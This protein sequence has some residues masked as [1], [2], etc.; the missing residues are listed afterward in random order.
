MRSIL[1][2]AAAFLMIGVSPLAFEAAASPGGAQPRDARM[3][4]ASGALKGEFPYRNGQLEGTVKWYYESGALGALMDY[5]KNRLHGYT[6]TFY[7][8]GRLKKVVRLDNNRPVGFAKFFAEDGRLVEVQHHTGGNPVSRW[9]HGGDG[10]VAVCE[11][12]VSLP[13]APAPSDKV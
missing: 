8:S 9:V 7:E 12:L 3:Y 5:R 1:T 10:R 2:L 4:Y 11:E 6:W 13:A